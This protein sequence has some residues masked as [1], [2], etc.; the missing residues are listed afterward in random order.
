MDQRLARIFTF[1]SWLVMVGWIVLIGLPFWD[2]GRTVVWA[3]IC[4]QCA[5]YAYLLFFGRRYDQGARPPNFKDF[6]SLKGVVR[7]F[8]NPR[9]AL[10]GWIHFLAFDLL[11][12]LL[13]LTDSQQHE[14]SHW[15]VAPILIVTL[16]VGPSGLLVY[17]VLRAFLVG[18]FPLL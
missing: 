8:E 13:I 5:V 1:Q 4:A 17:V 12:G 7:M 9:A 14:I 6:S 18:G 3:V 11:V 10:T 2:P 16:M 15:I